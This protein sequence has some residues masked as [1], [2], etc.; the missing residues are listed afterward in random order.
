MRREQREGELLRPAER[1]LAAKNERARGVGRGGKGAKE[2]RD[3]AGRGAER[4]GGGGSVLCAWPDCLP[5][6]PA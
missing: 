5:V 2:G 4:S 3:A 6:G 1:S